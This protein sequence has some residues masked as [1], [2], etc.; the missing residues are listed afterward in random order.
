MGSKASLRLGADRGLRLTDLLSTV[1]RQS[2]PRL[3]DFNFFSSPD[4]QRV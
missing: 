3:H 4:L 1:S 2:S